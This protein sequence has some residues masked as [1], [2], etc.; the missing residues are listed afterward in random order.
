MEI[1]TQIGWHKGAFVLPECCIGSDN[2]FFQSEYF[3]TDIP[4]RQQGTLAQWQEQISKY[5]V[6]NPLL[7]LSMC[8]SFAGALLH[9]THQQGGGFHIYG[10]SS[11][12]KTTGL[13]VACSVWG[14]RGYKRTWKATSNGMEASCTMFNDSLLALDEIAECD[15]LEIG[16]IVYSLGNGVGKQ[17]MHKGGGARA[18]F[19][20]QLIVLSNGELSLED[21]MRQE[22]KR[23]KAG[24]EL[25][26]LSIPIFGKYGAF[27]KLHDMKGGLELSDHLQTQTTKIYGIAGIEYLKK[28]VK[29]T[30]NLDQLLDEY[31]QALTNGELLSSQELRATKRFALIALAGEIAT[32]YGITGWEKGQAL[33]DIHICFQHWR[34]GFGKG[35]KEDQQILQEVKGYI[36]KYSDSRFTNRKYELN[37]VNNIRAGYW[38]DN[39]NGER[40]YLFNTAGMKDALNTSGLER[41]LSTLKKHGWLDHAPKRLKKKVRINSNI[42]DWFYCVKIPVDVN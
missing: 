22:G 21:V 6:N 41:G 40:T 18:T 37:Y 27:D 30:R 32:E 23:V 35:D 12:G 8:S 39:K 10:D 15:P 38:E 31:L 14:D 42:N 13:F 16:K 2:Y 33:T 1:S 11:K 29:E 5:C 3:N 28:L 26:L 7:M 19:Q 34:K 17:R 9:S 24:Q 4:Y 25:R 36:D 20:W